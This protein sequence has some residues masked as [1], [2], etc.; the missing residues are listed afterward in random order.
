ML[1][2]GTARPAQPRPA[3]RRARPQAAGRHRDRARPGRGR[4]TSWSRG[5]ARGDRAARARPRRLLGPQPAPG[6]RPDDRL[7][8]GRPVGAGGRPR[9]ELHRDHRRA[10]RPRPGQDRPHFPTNLV[11]DFGGGS[12]YLVIGV[13]AALLEA[14]VSGEGQVVDAAIVDGTAHLNTMTAAFLAAGRSA[15]ERAGE[16]ARRRGAVLRPLR[17]R[18]RQ[19]HVGRR[20][21]A[22]VLRRSISSCS[23]SR[24]SPPTATTPQRTEEL[25]K[26]I[27]ETFAAGPR[28]SGPRCST[29]PTPASRR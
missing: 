1:A 24:T 12:T 25:R 9:P 4:P 29:R 7:G 17:D 21:R 14:R 20:A 15:E 28:P 6:L 5:C 26:V 8:P 19:A 11:G 23:A 18:R 2:G 22:A 27:A 16:P 3:Q 10:A 13:L